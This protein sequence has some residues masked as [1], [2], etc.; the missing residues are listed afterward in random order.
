MK[1]NIL[2]LRK[3]GKSYREIAEQ[4]DIGIQK[5]EYYCNPNRKE[6][7]RK[8][9]IK[10]RNKNRLYKKVA[11]FHGITRNRVPSFSYREFLEKVGD[12]PICYITRKK[13]DLDD[14]KSYSIDHIIPNSK[15]G[16]NSLEN[17]GLIRTDI[18]QMKRDKTM[19]EFLKL[20]IEVVESNG[21]KIEKTI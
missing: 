20:C 19:D 4:L 17:A 5:V 14:I 3:T 8:A 12:S 18:N 1:D 11:S 7:M 13:I 16:N 21:F 9:A 6:M 15:G 10:Y 2:A